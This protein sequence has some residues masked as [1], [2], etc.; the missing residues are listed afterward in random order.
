M[1][2]ELRAAYRYNGLALARSIILDQY[3]TSPE[4]SVAQQAID[5][6]DEPRWKT[7]PAKRRM[8]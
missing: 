1:K 7:V 3:A 2:P 8:K 4:K 5:L 6:L